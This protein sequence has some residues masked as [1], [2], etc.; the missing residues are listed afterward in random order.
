MC[1]LVAKFNTTGNPVR[2]ESHACPD[3]DVLKDLARSMYASYPRGEYTLIF[4]NKYPLPLKFRVPLTYRGRCELSRTEWTCQGNPIVTAADYQTE[5]TPTVRPN[6]STTGI[7]KF[8]VS[9]HGG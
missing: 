1:T 6:P 9:K 5:D 2:D 8:L 4:D 3:W 7:R